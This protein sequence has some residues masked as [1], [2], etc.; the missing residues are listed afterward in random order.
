MCQ[1]PWQ[2]SETDPGGLG[3]S[4]RHSRLSWDQVVLPASPCGQE[5]G[6]PSQAR[7]KPG[8]ATGS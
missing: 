6:V 7:S 2:P 4:E 5:Q 3:R 8:P 1:N